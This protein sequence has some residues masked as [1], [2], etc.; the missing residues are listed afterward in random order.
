MPRGGQR[1]RSAATATRTSTAVR[2]H[3]SYGHNTRMNETM[4]ILHLADVHLDRPFVGLPP[5]AASGV[6]DLVL[7]RRGGRP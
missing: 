6:R 4:R 2:N 5:E 3:S 1:G 7:E